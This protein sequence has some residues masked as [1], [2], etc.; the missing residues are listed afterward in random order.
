MRSVKR[1]TGISACLNFRSW[2]HSL[3]NRS[4]WDIRHS[5][6]RID[7]GFWN[8]GKPNAR[9]R[10]LELL[11]NNFG[12]G[13]KIVTVARGSP[14][15]Y[16]L[17]F[18]GKDVRQKILLVN[19]RDRKI[20]LKLPQQ[21]KQIEW[22]SQETKGEPPKTEDSSTDRVRLSGYEGWQW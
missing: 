2:A 10:I 7:G 9:F 16:T 13:D 12:P 22:V 6:K 14:Y 1:D 19:K 5:P 21:A 17:G 8:N 11:K 18:I 20:D 3:A 4:W 15:V